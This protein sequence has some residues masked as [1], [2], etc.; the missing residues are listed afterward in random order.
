MG[1]SCEGE[2]IS[3]KHQFYTSSVPVDQIKAID[4]L[5]AYGQKAID[6]IAEVINLSDISDQVREYGQEA[7]EDIKRHN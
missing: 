7:I 3:A 2:I 4:T 5:A 6:A 1:S